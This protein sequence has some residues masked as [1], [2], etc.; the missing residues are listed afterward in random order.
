MLHIKLKGIERRAPWKLIFCPYTPS[1]PG[2]WSKVQIFFFSESGHV[3]YQTKG[4]EVLTNTQSK[5]LS[6]HIPLVLGFGVNGQLL[7][8]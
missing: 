1:I 5:T 7:K 4:K 2:V 3:A 8:L 6:L